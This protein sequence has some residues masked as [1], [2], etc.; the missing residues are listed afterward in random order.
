M[1][2][3][4]RKDLK[5]AQE[6]RAN[7]QS[8]DITESKLTIENIIVNCIN[9]EVEVNN[10]DTDILFSTSMLQTNITGEDVCTIMEDVM[11]DLRTLGYNVDY[12]Y[13]PESKEKRPNGRVYPWSFR[14]FISWRGV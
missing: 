10:F 12:E 6:N 1:S 14:L 9:E 8:A 3:L 11:N 2:L 4:N 13:S 7:M 5:T